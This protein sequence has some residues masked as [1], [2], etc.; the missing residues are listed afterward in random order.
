[1]AEI[2]V[3][4]IGMIKML[5][6]SQRVLTIMMMELT[7]RKKFEVEVEPYDPSDLDLN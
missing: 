4:L 2:A 1:M 3:D 7:S 5:I 6:E